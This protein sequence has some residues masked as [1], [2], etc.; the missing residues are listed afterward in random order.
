MVMPPPEGVDAMRSPWPS[1]IPFGSRFAESEEVRFTRLAAQWKRET[2]MASVDAFRLSHPAYQKILKMG[3]RAIPL[4]LEELLR[5][6]DRWL[7]ALEILAEPEVD[8]VRPG[9]TYKQAIE[10]WIHWGK[11]H[12]Y[13][14]PYNQDRI[15]S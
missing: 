5:S 3:E 8:P 2:G 1:T 15:L 13:L 7:D 11:V 9:A 10:D 14:K 12:G 4:I 6:P